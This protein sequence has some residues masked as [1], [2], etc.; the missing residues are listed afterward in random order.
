ME[1]WKREKL[2]GGIK[3]EEKSYQTVGS[4]IEPEEKGVLSRERTETWIGD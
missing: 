1:D 3:T 4:R 2:D